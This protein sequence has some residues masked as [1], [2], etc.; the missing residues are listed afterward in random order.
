MSGTRKD[1]LIPTAA[2]NSTS[3]GLVSRSILP[4]PRW[5]GAPYH[6][7]KYYRDFAEADQT[8]MIVDSINAAVRSLPRSLPVAQQ[9]PVKA[10]IDMVSLRLGVGVEWLKPGVGETT[11][12]LQRRLPR[13]VFISPEVARDSSMRHIRALAKQRDVPVIHADTSPYS[14][15]GVVRPLNAC[16]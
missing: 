13:C 14:C 11:R 3:C 1:L 4:V 16:S 8:R 6:G 9:H 12:V 15:V 7:A 10:T 5:D 2:L